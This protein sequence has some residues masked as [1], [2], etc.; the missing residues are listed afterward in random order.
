VPGKGLLGES[1][2][3]SRAHFET[4]CGAY[5]HFKLGR[6]LLRFTADAR[7]G[8]GIE[9]VLCVPGDCP[10]LDPAELNA[11][12]RADSAGG[13]ER[14]VV[15]V[16]DRHGT[17]TNGLLLAPPDAIAPS[18]GPG[19]CERH[20]A[21]ALAAGQRLVVAASA[22]KLIPF[23]A[24]AVPGWFQAAVAIYDANGNANLGGTHHCIV[25]EI[26]IRKSAARIDESGFSPP[27]T[28][29]VAFST[30]YA[31]ITGTSRATTIWFTKFLK[32]VS[33]LASQL[34]PTDPLAEGT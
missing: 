26:D 32:T 5:A 17:G 30:K 20:R 18:F 16:P 10:T 33:I 2:S 24:D 13:G 1:V 34:V 8:D 23:L 29:S 14:E 15:I 4:P 27:A 11:L 28:S 7:Y 9:R 12:L 25:A 3:T 22:R 31:A 6:Y 19:S 21:L